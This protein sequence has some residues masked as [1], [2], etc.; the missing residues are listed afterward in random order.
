MIKSNVS[1]YLVD[2]DGTLFSENT[3]FGFMLFYFR[4]RNSLKSNVLK[5]Y[6][7]SFFKIPLYIA[8][9]LN[10]DNTFRLAIH[11]LLKSESIHSVNE[12]AREYIEHILRYKKNDEVWKHIEQQKNIHLISSSIDPVINALGKKMGASW[13]SSVLEKKKGKLTGKFS[14]DLKGE[15]WKYLDSSIKKS[16][17]TVITDNR[18]D[19]ELLKHAD[20]RYVILNSERHRSFWE[21]NLSDFTFIKPQRT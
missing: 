7:S 4:K 5:L 19:L 14:M 11:G 10:L 1:Y 9:R 16:R 6:R 13:Q 3:A 8:G 20:E 17:I 15:K 21:K 18:D 2:V 12:C